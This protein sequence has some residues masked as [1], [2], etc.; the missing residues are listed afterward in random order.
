MF[1]RFTDEARRVVVYAQ[2]ESRALD[3]DYIGTEH[4]LLALLSQGHGLG[5][6]V[7]AAKGMEL[8]ATRAEVIR[9]VGRGPRFGP[10]PEA[11]AAIGIDLA[12]V[13]ERIEEEFGPGALE[14]GRS[15][16]RKGGA[17]GHLRFTPRAKKTIELAL[18]Q[19]LSLHQRHIA[20]EHILLG[21]L[22]E[23]SGVAAK[24]LAANGVSLEE[25]RAG[26]A[27]AAGPG[28]DTE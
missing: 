11:L 16:C 8:E 25:T 13:R 21:L 6:R 22:A 12:A 19:A 27:R 17:P 23:R 7:L 5:G 26:V 18:R 1:E 2:H 4:I 15:R 3:H 9:I 28:R 20:S 10:D 14:G 24:I